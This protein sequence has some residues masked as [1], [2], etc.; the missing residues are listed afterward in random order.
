MSPKLSGRPSKTTYHH[1]PPTTTHWA[2]TGYA[3]RT[4]T[5]STGSSSGCPPA[6]RGMSQPGSAGQVRPRCAA[7]AP[8]GSPLGCST[9]SVEEA[10]TSYDKV[11]GL[12]LSQV[13]VDGSLHKAPQGGE[14]TGPNPTD[15]AKIG[16]KWSLATDLFADPYR[17]GHSRSEPRRLRP[18]RTHLASRRQP[19]TPVRR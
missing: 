5:A 9:S 4:G 13:A 11:I 16:W 14:G 7:G 6:A 18:D 1:G 8:N 19:R 12:D 15:R 3:S 17:L 10:I 2:A